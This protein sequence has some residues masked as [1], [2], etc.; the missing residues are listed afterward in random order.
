MTKVII[1]GLGA[2]GLTY[3]VQLREKC[4]L[5]ILA[6][7]QRIEKYK[8]H[9][10]VFNGKEQD[11]TYIL[12]TDKFDA[13]LIIIT[14]KM[15]GLKSAINSIKNFVS[16]KTR[17]ISL[18]N[19]ISSEKIISE[20][21]PEAK[22]LKSYFIGHSAVRDGNN[23]TQD[24]TGTIVMEHDDFTEMFFAKS[25]INY[26]VPKDI[27]Y[28]MWLKF[29]LNVF[30][31]QVSAILDMNFG[32]LKRNKHFIEFAKKITAEVRLIAKKEGIKNLE[33]LEKDAIDALNIAIDEGKTSMH[34]DMLA[35]RPTEVDIFAGEIIRL[36]K[37]Y[38]IPTPYNQTLYD[39]VKIKEEDNE[40][41]IHTC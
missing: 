33:N 31:N 9:K 28:A 15:N 23:V 24:G 36:G 30:S 41:S 10:P 17:I 25:G 3:A 40:Y 1:I 32:G 14:T 11:F 26:S 37:K 29:S 35:K 8:T 34:Q 38:G 4:D 2:V 16:P 13:D 39:L 21:Y 18:I 12:P 7:E 5:Y 19:G 27:D 22:I 6:D 20:S